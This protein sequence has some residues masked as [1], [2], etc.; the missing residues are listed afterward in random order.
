[1]VPRGGVK[2]LLVFSDLT[3]PTFA[4][5]PIEYQWIFS[6]LSHPVLVF[7]MLSTTNK[8]LRVFEMAISLEEVRRGILIALFSDDELMDTLVLKGGNALALV[9]KVGFRTS[10]DMDFSMEAPFADLE[11]ARVRIF[12][13]LKREFESIGYVLFDENFEIKPSRRREGQPE[14]WGGYLVEFKLAERRL[15]EELHND[16]DALRRRAE[17]V[18]PQQMR[19]YAIDISHHE[20]CEGKVRREVDDYTI[21]VYSL[22]MIAAEKLRAIC[23]QMPEYLV[24]RTK[25]PRARDFYDIHQVISEHGIDLTTNEN[26]STLAA[27]FEAKQVPLNLLG[28]I[29]KYRDYHAQDWP[30]VEASIS[31]AHDTFDSYFDFVVKL[32]SSLEA[33][34]EK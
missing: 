25:R 19:K 21:Y 2:H 15:Y 5:R 31:S 18:G 33:F 22:E 13:T 34:R 26:R 32:A 29:N 1:M 6:R 9:H 8:A 3:C 24:L 7:A 23:Q 30:A 20:F 4:K 17:V 28:E 27:I 11:K 16:I 12:A 10:V 14:W